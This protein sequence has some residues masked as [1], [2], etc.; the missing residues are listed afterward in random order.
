MNLKEL[1]SKNPKKRLA[2]L[3]EAAKQLNKKTA[4][5]NEISRYLITQ[6]PCKYKWNDTKK[7]LIRAGLADADQTY[8]IIQELKRQRDNLAIEDE[9][10]TQ[11]S[12]AVDCIGE[13]GNNHLNEYLK[14]IFSVRTQRVLIN[15]VKIHTLGELISLTE[16]Q[17]LS[18][19]TFGK[20]C[21]K[22]VKSKLQKYGLSLKQDK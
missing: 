21:L 17:L 9:L 8:K 10:R 1:I 2:I 19:R 12:E 11:I 4:D 3:I 20:M 5:L 16:E 6:N 18:N 14:D 15:R 22:E 13:K 7:T